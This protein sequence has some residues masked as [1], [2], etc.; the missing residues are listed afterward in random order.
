MPGLRRRLE[1]AARSPCWASGT[2]PDGKRTI[3]FRR[4]SPKCSIQN[5]LQG[6]SCGSCPGKMWPALRANCPLTDEDSLAKATLE[7]LRT[8]PGADVVVLGSYTVLP[9]VGKSKIRLDVRMQDTVAGETIAEEALSGDES[10]LF[11]LASQVG[12]SLRH[13]LGLGPLP[14]AIVT[15]TRAALPMNENAARLYAEGRAKLWAFDFRGARDLLI[16]AVAADPNYPLAH[17]ALSD[18]WWHSGYEAKARAEGQRAIELSSQLS[19]EQ[20]LLVEG[21]YRKTIEDWPKAIEAYRSLFNLFPDNLDYGIALAS[22]QIHVRPSDALETLAVLRRLPP[23]MGEDAR[24]DMTEA[25]AWIN[26]DF[27]RARAAA[28][29]AIAKASAQGSHVLVARVHGI[30]CQQAPAIDASVESISECESALQAAI[31]AKDPNGVAMMGTDLAA[32]YFGRGDLTRS[33]E[34]FNRAVAEFR[35]VGNPDGVGT[36]LGNFASIR[37]W[38][39]DLKEAKKIGGRVDSRVPDRGRQRRRGLV[40]GHAGR[41]VAAQG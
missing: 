15:A 9:G 27:N 25:S 13:G 2:C 39:G 22:A 41:P 36:A 38:Q 31:V 21:Q 4:P 7:R 12:N 11:D 5:S 34:M 18:V 24:I 33:G 23:P 10:D 40:P 32:L 26:S 19:Q 6:A 37:L 1:C 35:Q 8:D 30:L 16:K 14:S 28:K 20:R 29:K 3:G 17:S